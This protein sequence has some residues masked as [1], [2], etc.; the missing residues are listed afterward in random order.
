M[1]RGAILP[2]VNAKIICLS[3]KKSFLTL[4]LIVAPFLNAADEKAPAASANP[5]KAPYPY[6]FFDPAKPIVPYLYSY[7]AYLHHGGYAYPIGSPLIIWG[8]TFYKSP[9]WIPLCCPQPFYCPSDGIVI[10]IRL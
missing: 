9:C 2:L 6:S 7:P 8:P 3:M 5:K 1:V 10:K 4:I